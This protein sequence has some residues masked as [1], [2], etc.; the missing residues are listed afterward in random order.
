MT[1]Q[2]PTN[3]SVFLCLAN[4]KAL[5]PEYIKHEGLR[6]RAPYA[7]Y[8]IYTNTSQYPI[9]NTDIMNYTSID[10][11]ELQAYDCRHEI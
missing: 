7:S 8:F 5:K 2:L 4:Q 1:S 6:S 9:L 10:L 3:Q 11:L